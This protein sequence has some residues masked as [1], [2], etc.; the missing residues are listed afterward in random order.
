MVSLRQ[1]EAIRPESPHQLHR[2][3]EAVLDIHVPRV[4]HVNGNTAPFEYLVHSFFED[5]SCCGDA[6]VWANRGG[7]KTFLGA[8]A[9]L[10]DLVFKPGVQ[11]RILGGSFEQSSKMYRYLRQL[12]ELPVLKTLLMG[13]PTQRGVRLINGSEAEV[14]SQSQRSI[15]GERV[16]KIRCDEVEEFN[17]EVWQAVQLTTRSGMCGDIDVRGS[18][19]ALSTMHR[20][21][22]LMSQLVE[23]AQVGEDGQKAQVFRWCAMDVIERCPP[24]RDCKSCVL[25]NDCQGRAKTANGFVRVDDLVA[26]WHRTSRE[27]WASEMMCARPRRSDCVYPNF[28]AS[29]GGSHV[30][31]T[32]LDSGNLDR[33][34]H[35]GQRKLGHSTI[36]HSGIYFVGGMDFGLR[37][38]FVMLWARLWP[39]ET[40]DVHGQHKTTVIEVVDEYVESGLTLD[41]HVSVIKQRDWPTPEWLGVDPAGSQRNSHT[42]L[43][44]IDIL[45][46]EGFKVRFVRSNVR[47][48]VEY[49]RRRLDHKTLLIASSCRRL[50]EALSSYHFD[51]DRPDRDEPVKDGP[52]HLC[53]ALRYMIVNLERPGQGVVIRTY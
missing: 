18:V 44:D 12:F 48:G 28:D 25:W 21:F 22:G 13:E 6:I 32:T 51:A 27:V 41:Q 34:T 1:I 38:P 2:F 7:G 14:L 46:R 11:V 20:P 10:M 31:R 47:L 3:I 23:N 45:R 35:Q 9:T 53:D 50:I 15:R 39:G 30:L 5:T 40:S 36:N 33:N 16:H 49:V 26:Q 24:V 17:R 52:D 42:G 29:I 4:V 37:S 19:E 8:V 43:S